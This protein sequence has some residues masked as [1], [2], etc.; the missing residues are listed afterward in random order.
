MSSILRA[1]QI[2]LV[3]VLCFLLSPSKVVAIAW[4][5]FIGGCLIIVMVALGVAGILS[6]FVK[7]LLF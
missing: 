1:L 3:T 6:K 5:I 4:A 2:F 7:R